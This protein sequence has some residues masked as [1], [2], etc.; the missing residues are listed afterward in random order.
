[1]GRL[2][3]MKSLASPAAAGRTTSVIPRSRIDANQGPWAADGVRSDHGHGI[4]DGAGG[5]LVAHDL[6]P[7]FAVVALVGFAVRAFALLVVV[8]PAWRARSVGMMEGILGLV[9]VGGLALTW[10]G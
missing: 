5:L 8:R 2:A 4:P 9:F 10:G 6:A 1:M 7:F 3:Y